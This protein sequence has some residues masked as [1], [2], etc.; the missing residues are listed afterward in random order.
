MTQDDERPRFERWATKA[1]GWDDVEREADGEY[2]NNVVYGA[3]EAWKHVLC[4]REPRVFEEVMNE[5]VKAGEK[6]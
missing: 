5:T 3:W 6:T 2:A 4:K 1:M